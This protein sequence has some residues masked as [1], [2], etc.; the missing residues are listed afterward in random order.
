MVTGEPELKERGLRFFFRYLT[1]YRKELFQLILG[2]LV[3]SL[4]QLIL[5]FLTQA[6]VDVGI[7]DGNLSFIT[8]VLVAQIIISVSQ[9]S[10]EFIRSWIL[11]HVNTRISISLISDFLA[12]LM[13]LPLHF[14]DT[15]MVGDII[16]RIGDHDR[17][18]NFL[19]GS[20]IST[21]FSFV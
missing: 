15:K 12:K 17:I 11:L 5:P 18:K 20:S 8:L 21:L 19:T 10:V 6:L 16:Q 14:F 3:V 13:K 2:M 7:S 9:L 1:P 4:L